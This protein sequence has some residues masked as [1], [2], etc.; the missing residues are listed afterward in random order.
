MDIYKQNI[1]LIDIQFYSVGGLA[2]FLVYQ[3][4]VD[5]SCG[6]VSVRQHFTLNTNP[7][8]FSLQSWYA[9]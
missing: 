9:S 3:I 6:I 2:F 5:L 8:D 7:V 1:L 4:G